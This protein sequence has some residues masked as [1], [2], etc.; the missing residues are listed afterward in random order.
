MANGITVTSNPDPAQLQSLGVIGLQKSSRSIL[1]DYTAKGRLA[2]AS[3]GRRITVRR[4][5]FCWC[6]ILKAIRELET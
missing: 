2:S 5:R 6:R 1:L 3:A 4:C